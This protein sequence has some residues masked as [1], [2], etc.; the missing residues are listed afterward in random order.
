M[1]LRVGAGLTGHMG[2]LWMSRQLVIDVHIARFI[3]TTQYNMW[4]EAT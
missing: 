1:T 2:R 3:L 4:S